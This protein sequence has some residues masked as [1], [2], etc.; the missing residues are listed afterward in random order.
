LKIKVSNENTKRIIL[1]KY[2]NPRAICSNIRITFGGI[3]RTYSTKIATLKGKITIY[4]IEFTV[5]PYKES[6]VGSK[7]SLSIKFTPSVFIPTKNFI[8]IEA[9]NLRADFSNCQSHTTC[10]IEDRAECMIA[11]CIISRG[12]IT[13]ILTIDSDIEAN[14]KIMFEFQ[15]LHYGNTMKPSDLTLTI[16]YDN[17]ENI[18]AGQTGEQDIEKA[19]NSIDWKP[20][21]PA[22]LKDLKMEFEPTD[23]LTCV[24]YDIKFS[25]IPSLR[26][27]K[28]SIVIIRFSERVSIEEANAELNSL[29]KDTINSILNGAIQRDCGIPENSVCSFTIEQVKMPPVS[30]NIEA[31]IETYTSR[32]DE[33]VHSSSASKQVQHKNYEGTTTIYVTPTPSSVW[34]EDSYKFTLKGYCGTIKSASYSIEVPKYFRETVSP[35]LVSPGNDLEER[36]S[37]TIN[38]KLYNPPWEISGSNMPDPFII[39]VLEQT[40]IA[41]NI[42]G[43]IDNKAEFKRSSIQ[44]TVIPGSTKTLD[45]CQYRFEFKVDHQIPSTGKIDLISSMEWIGAPDIKCKIGL[46]VVNCVKV[47]NIITVPIL[48]TIENGKLILIIENMRNPPFIG[49]TLSFT[50]ILYEEADGTNRIIGETTTSSTI[51]ISEMR[52]I[53][54]SLI[55]MTSSVNLETSEYTFHLYPAINIPVSYGDIHIGTS[56]LDITAPSQVSD[57]LISNKRS[58][59]NL[60]IDLSPSTE[61]S[62]VTFICKNPA[63]T[64]PTDYFH[65]TFFSSDGKPMLFGKQYIKTT[66]G[67]KVLNPF[68]NCANNHTLALTRCDIIFT[69][70]SSTGIKLL[71]IEGNNIEDSPTCTGTSYL[72]GEGGCIFDS[73]NKRLMLSFASS[74]TNVGRINGISVRNPSDSNIKVLFTLKTYTDD[75]NS[76]LVD[77][78]QNFVHFTIPCN[79]YCKECGTSPNNCLS[80]VYDHVRK[81]QYYLYPDHKCEILIVSGSDKKCRSGHYPDHTKFL[82]LPCDIPN[83]KECISSNN[84]CTECGSSFFLFNGK[85]YSPTEGCPDGS[86]QSGTIC[87]RCDTNCVTCTNTATECTKC[88]HDKVLSGNKCSS[89]CPPNMFANNNKICESCRGDCEECTGTPTACT[90]CTNGKY[91]LNKECYEKDECEKKYHIPNDL[92]FTCDKCTNHCE[93]CKSSVDFCIKCESSYN[94]YKNTCIF[95]CPSDH[96]TEDNVCNECRNNCATCYNAAACKTCKGNTYF[97]AD[98]LECLVDCTEGYY[99]HGSNCIK[100]HDSCRTCNGPHSSSCLSCKTN[101]YLYSSSC[102]T[103]CPSATYKTIDKCIDCQ[104]PCASCDGASNRCTN[105]IGG[106]N[107]Y[108]QS[109]YTVCPEGTIRNSVSLKCEDCSTSCKSCGGEKNF[110]TSCYGNQYLH[111]GIC[112]SQCPN[113]TAPDIHSSLNSCKSCSPG[114]DKCT[115]ESTNT[116]TPKL[117]ITC[118][119]NYKHL[120]GTC[121]SHCPSD[122]TTSSDG[123]SCTRTSISESK[124]SNTDYLPFPH[125][126]TA[127][128]LGVATTAGQY[129]DVRSFLISNLIVV[130]SYTATVCYL[131]KGT[132]AMFENELNLMVASML[133]IGIQLLLNFLFLIPYKRSISID[134]GFSLWGSNNKFIKGLIVILSTIFSLQTYR[135]FYSRFMGLNVLFAQFENYDCLFNPLNIYSLLQVVLIHCGMIVIDVFALSQ[136]SLGANLYVY[137][138]ES[139]ILSLVLLVLLCYELISSK[140][141]KATLEKEYTRLNDQLVEVTEAN[142]NRKEM[143]DKVFDKL[144]KKNKPKRRRSFGASTNYNK[145]TDPRRISSFPSSPKTA[146]DRAVPLK[147]YGIDEDRVIPPDELPNAVYSESA[148]RKKLNP[149]KPSVDFCC[150]SPTFIK[151]DA[152]KKHLKVQGYKFK[153]MFDNTPKLEIIQESSDEHEDTMSKFKALIP[154]VFITTTP[155]YAEEDKCMGT[156]RPISPPQSTEEGFLPTVSRP[157]PYNSKEQTLARDRVKK[158]KSK[159]KDLSIINKLPAAFKEKEGFKCSIT[160]LKQEQSKVRGVEEVNDKDILG[161]FDIDPSDDCILIRENENGELVDLRNRIVNRYGYLIDKE[162]NIINQQGLFFMSKED[163][164][165]ETGGMDN[166]R[167]I[168]QNN[169]LLGSTGTVRRNTG[170]K[171]T[172]DFSK[173]DIMTVREKSIQK[174]VHKETRT[175]RR[176]SISLDSLMDDSPSKYNNQNQRYDGPSI[177]TKG[178]VE[179]NKNVNSEEILS[180]ICGVRNRRLLHNRSSYKRKEEKIFKDIEEGAVTKMKNKHKFTPDNTKS[181]QELLGFEEESK[182]NDK[183]VQKQ[184]NKVIFDEEP[185]LP[186]QIP[187]DF[188][189]LVYNDKTQGMLIASGTEDLAPFKKH[190]HPSRKNGKVKELKLA[191]SQKLGESS[192]NKKRKGQSKRKVKSKAHTYTNKEE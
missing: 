102:V 38:F 66:I 139:L 154:S 104:I 174:E 110:C 23:I 147:K 91:L 149:I 164:E 128:L 90:K 55:S 86:Y 37:N 51:R 34:H 73:A 135:F 11:S 156:K 115:W 46:I 141:T 184:M 76:A 168:T 81:E 170:T 35:I 14:K 123:F 36:I 67:S 127:V 162:G 1:S 80:C 40:A 17:I 6:V 54:V 161:E 28:D 9:S 8:L 126:I 63:T 114:C 95:N 133:P 118:N 78:H 79:I 68:I 180:S 129:R 100:C 113:Q 163:F 22:E 52:E 45:R 119:W 121:V 88:E 42:K 153:K 177:G 4:D 138:I 165:R 107:L 39:T 58:G 117:C 7:N 33:L 112:H 27:N 101:T 61:F 125:L 92:T 98:T 84:Q 160:G 16:S 146:K 13:I 49:D 187:K 47:N 175:D 94:L 65:F 62:S 186:I 15:G 159:A 171:R 105:C 69:R 109:C 144:F 140:N 77:E 87:A 166:S 19:I 155:N 152:F 12:T 99:K 124:S 82:C 18:C 70:Q 189:T 122:Y 158:F 26:I 75:I 32:N 191:Y 21:K 151:I 41:F 131:V 56:Y 172:E 106:Y 181:M 145:E 93:Q 182:S 179:N 120:D 157:L 24:K 190:F 25:F 108:G 50:A 169:P 83:C 57:C 132:T 148:P 137:V 142:K 134:A 64:N 43:Y 176:K 44:L 29:Q 185:K 53:N 188:Q 103:D 143:L 183:I 167:P 3:T 192:K 96:Y 59:C 178:N 48:T 173:K 136:F 30:G 116:N 5:I 72:S 74:Q 150:Q 10:T 97:T 130:F 31:I 71:V 60:C 85:C 2:V 20:A 89:I 111:N